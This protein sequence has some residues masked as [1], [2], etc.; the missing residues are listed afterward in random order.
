MCETPLH[1]Q[2]D[3]EPVF[4]P[5]TLFALGEELES[6]LVASSVARTYLRLLAERVGR[7]E[8]ALTTGDEE[9][10]LEVLLSLRVTSGTVGARRLAARTTL[11]IDA[12]E[13]DETERTWECLGQLAH[14]TA[15]TEV[16]LGLHL[17]GW[18]RG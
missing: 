17:S 2:A 3:L 12:V 6:Q 7:I 14:D 5:G 8:A 16:A 1:L 9:G 10:A 11:L 4:E 18:Q 13:A 15:E